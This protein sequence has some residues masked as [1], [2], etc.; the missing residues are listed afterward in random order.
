VALGVCVI[1][2]LIFAGL[3]GSVP[4]PS[5]GPSHPGP[6]SSST[7]VKVTGVDWK[8]A[9]PD[10]WNATETGGTSVRGGTSFNVSLSLSYTG[11]TSQPSSCTVD[12]DSVATPGFVLV[13]SNAPLVIGAGSTQVLNLELRAPDQNETEALT[14]ES[15]VSTGATP[16]MVTVTGV[17]WDL[18]GPTNCWSTMSGNGTTVSG[19]AT[20]TVSINLSYSASGSEPSSCTVQS[21]K[22]ATAGFT[23]LSADT[24]LVVDSGS[25]QVLSVEARA[26]D[27]N[28]SEALTVNGTVTTSSTPTT[29]NVTAVN[30]D[31]SGPSNC[32]GT[33]SG[34]GTS[35]TGGDQFTVTI[36]LSYTAG[37]LDPST[38]T[39]QSVV[40]NTTGFTLVS[41][42]TPLVVDSGGSQVLSVTLQAPK[43]SETTVLALDCTVTSP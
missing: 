34:S 12:S 32:W 4:A 35:V 8:F 2:L 21:V 39:V 42:N 15:T 5:S 38:C 30:W 10:C 13:S 18:S 40:V 7:E 37:L 25:T 22:L 27:K 20:F 19:N 23:Y 6:G 16:I 36:Q 1:A 11:G 14:V 3:L 43:S 31:F 41:S 29:V 17:N 24:P 26:P 33:M 9:G 28:V